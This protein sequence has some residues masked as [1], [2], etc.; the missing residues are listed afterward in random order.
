MEQAY[1]VEGFRTAVG[2]AHKGAFK[3]TRSDDLAVAV[4]NHLIN[5]VPQIDP[6][7]IDD[8]IVGCAYPEGEQGL[9]M[10]RLIGLMCL[11]TK[12]PGFI[13][14]RFCGSGLESIAIA[15]QR[16]QAGMADIIIAGG[17]ES[18]TMI[19]RNGYKLSPNPE[20][21]INH[22][23]YL[24]SMGLTAENVAEKYHITRERQDEYSFLS[25]QK[26]IAA[27]N[28]GK[29]KNEIVPIT[30]KE[31]YPDHNEQI[32]IH[33]FVFSEDEGPRPDTSIEKLASLQPV[34]KQNGLITAGNSSPMNDGSSFVLVV[35]G[36]ALKEFNL[37]P[38]LR[39]VSYAAIGVPPEIMGIGPVEAVPLALQKAGLTL[40]DIDLI[41]LNEA[42]ASQAL[43]VID[44]LKLPIQKVNVNGGA[45]ALGHPLGATGAKLT[46]QLMNEMSRRNSRYG[47][48]TACIGG[49][50]GVAGIF[51]NLRTR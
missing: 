26:A 27:I 32:H 19:P 16:I 40:N 34:F 39:V 9:Q 5:A 8:L 23:E 1:I 43:A 51:E 22:P 48:V 44:Q 38:K 33:E 15:S 42:F 37:K 24:I 35:S 11:P 28:E 49:G 25:H 29:F 13:V 36:K 12:V 50:Q 6:G 31:R 3:S 17:T 7:R 14:N 46:T 41:E 20:M 47:I 10:G 21:A 30:I 18:M 45:I 2:R 4:I